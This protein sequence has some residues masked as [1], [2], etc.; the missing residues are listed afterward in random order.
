MGICR[1][2]TSRL[3][4]QKK[5]RVSAPSTCVRSWILVK[6]DSFGN[7]TYMCSIL[8]PGQARFFWE[9]HLHVF[10]PG[11]WS[12][13]ILLGT[14]P[15]CVRS[16][17]LV[18]PDSFGNDTYMCSILD[19]GQA[20]F[21]WER[22]LHVFDPGSWSSQILLGTTP[23]CVRSWILVKPD[24]FG[25]DTYM[26]S[27]LD[28]GQARFFW[29]RH[30]HVFDPGSWSSQILLGTTPT[31]VRSWILVKPDSFG[32]DTYMCSILDP[33]QA[34]FFWERHLHVFDPGS[35]SS[36]ILLGTTPTCVRSWI[37]VKPDSFGNDTYMCSILDP[38]QARFFWERHLHVFDPG[39]W[40]SQ[41]LLGTTPTCVR[42]WILVKPDSFGNDTYMCSILDP[43]QARF[44]WERHLHVFDPGS[45]SSQ[46]LL[47]TTPTCVRSWILVKPDSFGNDTYMCSILDPGQA[48][49]F[50]ERHLHVFDPGSWSSQILLGTT[51]TCVRSWIL[52][53]PDSFGNDTYMCSILDPGQARFFWERHL[54]VFD[55]G[56]W[57]SQILL[58]TT[59][60]CVRSWILVKPDSFGND[61]YMC[62][63]LDPGQARFFWERHLHVFDPGSWS[64]QIL[65]GTTPT[66][67]RSWILVKPDSFGNDTYMCSIL[68]P[69]QA[70]FFWERHL[71]VFDPGSWSS[72]ILLG[73]TPTCVRSWILVKPDLLGTTPTCVRSWILVKP[74][75][76]GNAT[77]MCSILDPGQARSFGND[78][79][80]CSI[81]PDLLGTTP[82]CVRSWILVKPDL[83]GTTPT[84][85]RSW[86]LVKPDSFGNDTYM[87]SILDP[88]QARFFWER[89]LHVFDPGSWSSQILLGTT[90]T[91]VRSWILVKP[92]SFGNDT[93]MCSI[94]DPGQ[95][96]SFGN[97]TYMCSILDPG[98]ARFFWERHLHVFDPGSWSSQIFWERHLHVFDPGSWSS[99]I[100]L[101]TT[102]TCVRSW[103][104]V[105]P[106]SFGNDTYMCSIL[107]PGQARSFGND[108]YMC[109]ILDPGQARFFWE[110]HL[111]VFDP[112]SWSS[113]IFWERHLHVFDPG[114]WS[115]QILLGTTPT[116]VRSWI[117]VK[118][119]S[120]GNDTYMCSILD[121]GQARFFWER[122]LHVFDPGSWSSQIL[123][124]TTP[125]C[126]R[127]WILVKPDSFGNDTYMCSIL[128]P[129]QARFFWERHLHVFDPGSWSSQILLR[130]TPTC[131]R[132]WILVKPD[133]F[134]NDTYMCSILDPGQ[135]RF[136][137]ERHL[138][139]FDPGSWS[140]QILLGTTP[141]C[142]RS[143]ILVKPDSFG[144]DTYMC[145]ILDPGQARFFW[146]R[147]LHVFDPG[148]WSSQI[149]LGT[150]PTCVRSWILV[151]PDSFAND[152]YMCSIL[153]PGQARFFWERHLHVFDP[154]SW[155]SQIL[156]G[157]TPTCVRSWILVKPDSFANDTYMCSILDP[158]QA[159]F[160]WERHLHVFDPGSW[161]SQIF[162][163][164]HLHVFDPGSW[165]S[166]IL[167]RTTPTCVRSWILVKPDSFGND[168]YMCSILDPG[169]ARFFWERHLHVFD[170]GSWSSQI[171]L[172]TTPTCVRSWI[173][174]KPDSF[175]NDTYMCSILDPGQARFFWERHLHVFD[176]GS[177]SSQILLGTTPTC[178]RSWILVKPDSF[179][180]DT[181]MCSILDPGQARSFGNDTYM[182]SIL[183]P[184]QARSFA[185]D[186][187]M[188][189][190]LDPGQ[191]RF[192]W[193]RHLHVFDPGSW[194][195]QIF[196]E[197]HLH[198][199]DPGSWSSQIFCE[200]HLHRSSWIRRLVFAFST[201][202]FSATAPPR[203]RPLRLLGPHGA[204]AQDFHRHLHGGRSAQDF[205][206]LL[207]SEKRVLG[208]PKG[209]W[210]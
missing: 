5:T 189:S 17:I 51:P 170:P 62:S 181:Y 194:S 164:R 33:G 148:S 11:S 182:C 60:T 144:N 83:L 75:S 50:W 209:E 169:Q 126:V 142:V 124:G 206:R 91:C 77:Y 120:F 154:G 195:S 9:R 80:M 68:D 89:H 103:I 197:R 32:N 133:S 165:S 115:S 97:D 37:L 13:Q 95:A 112:G 129:G 186:T 6:P 76:F 141:T 117:L 187:Y 81:K 92:D 59:P 15:T 145:S 150:T 7:D 158:G 135:A 100:L 134:G 49:F 65:L 99:Q 157:T 125:T 204:E 52:V 152:T 116:C 173:L 8:D 179:G 203:A 122:H 177:W 28:P 85:V 44:F 160:F 4:P 185:N 73:T 171:L 136:F 113:Q 111:H 174:V 178:V 14:T 132:S 121:P 192:F 191:A 207:W 172:G 156:L 64:S 88:G 210:S 155:S 20:R 54:H 143:W 21:F 198:V 138:H 1:H 118:P 56:S 202:L 175:G 90:P 153:D 159:R 96:R 205:H 35:W 31:C 74:D 48:R 40:S 34:R 45:W 12:S 43:G 105:K 29:E 61:T 196:C 70:R 146:E 128:D 63:I 176:P 188:C 66:C 25:N 183:D 38:G 119:D 101:G 72:Q 16:W 82:T 18:K 208:L 109:S 69:G 98:Q 24:S 57:S 22:H 102:P 167:L 78:T 39:S 147:H 2:T 42:S 10:D 19:P 149:L 139:V 127:S 58:G 163:E 108:T 53:K 71:H 200:R 201:N 84:C 3:S 36:Q 23:T 161:S 87:C 180:N 199:F 106:D 41:I 47:G 166:Q 168:T 137:W 107:D 79:Y 151:K 123:L 93:Y 67:V 130:T 162:W 193:E 140:S 190:I 131:V 26:C 55:P 110:R 46:I 94:L 184:G 27:I 104:L 86:I 30:L 114:S